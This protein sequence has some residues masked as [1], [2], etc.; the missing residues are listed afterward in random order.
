[1]VREG[2]PDPGSGETESPVTHGAEFSPVEMEA[3]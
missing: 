3:V 2:V 1:M